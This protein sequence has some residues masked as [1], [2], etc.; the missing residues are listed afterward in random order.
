[1]VTLNK[2]TFPILLRKGLSVNINTINTLSSTIQGELHYTIDTKQLYVN[3][4][5]KNVRALYLNTS[6][7]TNNYVIIE[8]D[9]YI[10]INASSVNIILTLPSAIGLSG[11]ILYLKKIDNTTNIVTINTNGSETIDNTSSYLLSSQ[12]DSIVIIS[13][14][15]NWNHLVPR[16][17]QID[18]GLT[19]ILNGVNTNFTTSKSFYNQ[20][21]VYVNGLLQ[22]YPTDYTLL[23]PNVIIFTSAPISGDSISAEYRV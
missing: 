19:G 6:N 20:M 21:K 3:D 12:W 2:T 23:L 7:K 16:L 14:G 18:Y 9:D 5:T 17:I 4:G 8:S 15:T 13:N 1:M 10:S 22:Y 11:K